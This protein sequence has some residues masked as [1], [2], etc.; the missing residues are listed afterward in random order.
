MMGAVE[1]TWNDS[2]IAELE[3]HYSSVGR[4]RWKENSHKNQARGLLSELRPHPCHCF[5][6]RRV[7]LNEAHALREL[8]AEYGA[9][10]QAVIALQ[11]YF[12]AAS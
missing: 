6:W 12:F 10:A 9:D 8:A 11:L 5:D 3:E 2:Q 7:H 4:R 1:R